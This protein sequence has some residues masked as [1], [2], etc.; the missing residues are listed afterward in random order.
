MKAA[1]LLALAA[2]APVQDR[3]L[4]W[5]GGREQPAPAQWRDGD[6][7]TFAEL[8][9]GAAP[10]EVK[11]GLVFD[12]PR[13]LCA[14]AV[15]FLSL[16]EHVYEGVPGAAALELLAPE[17]WCPVA[18]T[19]LRDESRR[20]E[21]ARFQQ[22]GGVA[23]RLSF[24]R[25]VAGGARLVVRGAVDERP[26][27]RRLVVRELLAVDDPSA[28]IRAIEGDAVGGALQSSRGTASSATPDEA[29][30]DWALPQRGA[31]LDFD[32][33]GVV[34]AWPRARYVDEVEVGDAQPAVAAAPVVP[35]VPAVIE[36]WDGEQWRPVALTGMEIA[37][38][39]G[40]GA[41]A[42][43]RFLPI[44]TTRLRALGLEEGTRVV[45]RL[46]E[47]A[48]ADADKVALS[49]PDLL[50]ER[51]LDFLGEPDFG[52]IASALLPPGANAAVIGRPGD[53]V[54]TLVTWNG[55]LHE[56]DHGDEGGWNHGA[57][58]SGGGRER[59]VDRWCAFALNGEL[60]GA[61]P[62]SVSRRLF[63]RGRPGVLTT[64]TR[65]E[66]RLSIEAF[67]TAPC[68]RAWATVVTLKVENLGR[69][70]ARAQVAALLGRRRHM[71]AARGELDLAP[72][73]SGHK[74]D[75]S[76]RRLRD[77]SGAI[78]LSTPDPGKLAAGIFESTMTFEAELAAG[79]SREFELLL[80][81]V[82]APGPDVAALT[83]FDFA[84]SR[85]RFSSFWDAELSTFELELPEAPLRE[86]ASALLAQAQIV[87]LDDELAREAPARD[88]PAR[89]APAAA[90]PPKLK[91]GAY[92]YEDYFGI[93]EAW[94]TVALAQF[95]QFAA[96]ERAAE[97]MLAPDLLDPANYHHQYRMGVA[98]T[99]AARVFALS[100]DP[101]FLA[102]IRPRLEAVADWIV[103]A[104]HREDG[105]GHGFE[106]LLPKHT[107]GG[108]VTT[109]A[110]SL[111]SNAACWRG[112]HE[113]AR[114]L[115]ETGEVER[116]ATIAREAAALRA[117]IA[118]VAEA[119]ADRSHDPPFVPMAVDLGEQDGEPA[120]RREPS[121]EFLPADPLGNYWSL[122][123]PLLLETGVF[124]AEGELSTAIRATRAERG[125]A[126]LELARF[127]GGIDPVYGLGGALA[128]ADAGEPQRF[129]AA[130][131]AFLAHALDRD[132]FTGGEV[133]GV[134]PL[135][136]SNLATRQRLAET[137]WHWNL[138]GADAM[139]DDAGRATGS[140]PLSASAGVALQLVRRL[141]LEE[142]PDRAAGEADAPTPR[143][144]HLLRLAPPHWL[145]EGKTIRFRLPSEFGEIRLA[146]ES[147]VDD[148]FVE[149]T[150]E[151]VPI[152]EPPAQLVLWLDHPEDATI[153]HVTLAGRTHTDFRESCVLLPT[154]GAHE[155]RVDF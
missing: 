16:Y 94:P 124:A 152:G 4:V 120:A 78:V 14:L 97:R 137:R 90:A 19:L 105:A 84:A 106:G 22:F 89:D 100:H 57:P 129:R 130:A 56:T 127:H 113:I 104:R 21:L 31:R 80:P 17:G 26:A 86:L 6:P 27:W 60:V 85:R 5:R 72:L 77:A 95:G 88:A 128:L 36:W 135:R 108:D 151:L 54:E 61:E 101:G 58:G 70:P 69:E 79:G 123:A 1:A 143:A 48:R 52:G 18:A 91:Y 93:E 23:W 119:A 11:I 73:S 65:G 15:D 133:L 112:L 38:G 116:A 13:P 115:H 92:A 24:P 12:A 46:G 43:T 153:D 39:D 66:L 7:G 109:P 138:Y 2:G 114:L 55:T 144:L 3:A 63:E 154:S 103:A 83:S 67:V 140:E 139:S 82:N 146:L 32:G 51:E 28:P 40:R 25:C 29:A 20:S 35:A 136:T 148:G 87:L 141:L 53:P 142:L 47:D 134:F 76:G 71:H 33:K 64:M 155:F 132:V 126:L 98:A 8:E 81:S 44:A 49:G 102:R 34:V 107:Y 59:W 10:S 99:A 147:H 30:I 118:E 74:A 150:V 125:G 145:A 45:V 68:D 62:D 131:Y 117:R 75:E 121:Y 41:R 96:A 9:A 122:F 50:L 42:T 110:R 149:G 111:Y 37:Q